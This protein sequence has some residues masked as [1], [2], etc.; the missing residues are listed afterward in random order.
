M[1]RPTDEE[2]LAT[3]GECFDD[4]YR[5]V[6]RRCDGD[7]DLTEDV[8]QETWLRAVK[9]WRTDGIPD[10]PMAWLATVATRLLSNVRRRKSPLDIDAIDP[11]APP[12]DESQGT[13]T[14]LERALAALP[15]LQRRLL[16]AFHFD[17]QRVADIARTSGLSERAVEGRL[18]RARQALR[19]Q[20]ETDPAS[21]EILP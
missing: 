8:V 21:R 13:R 17:E 5:V 7:R 1:S 3:Y 10:K 11:E 16:E 15:A 6:S 19:R 12:P 2:I 9:A 14:I 18:R 4:L 20:I